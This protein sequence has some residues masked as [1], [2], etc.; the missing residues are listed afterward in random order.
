LPQRLNSWKEIAAYLGREVRTVQRWGAERELPVHRLPGGDRP[1]VYALASELDSWLNASP[2]EERA[3]ASIA[4]LPFV[5]LCGHKENE[6]FSDGLADEIINALTRVPGLRVS[7]RTSAFAFRGKEQ[8]VREIGQRLGVA[9]L[10]EG[11]VRR[12]ANRV[13]ISAQLVSAQDGYHLW[14]ECY[15]RELSDIFAIQDELAR[16]IARALRVRLVPGPLV[17]RMTEDPEAYDLWLKGRYLGLRYTQEDIAA[18]RECFE[19][20]MAR[21]PCFP[22]PYVSIA[23]LLFGAAELLQLS[24]AEARRAR[25][26]VLKALELNERLGEAHALLGTLEGVMEY[27]WDSAGRAFERAFELTP[28]SSTVLARHAWSFLVPHRR[29][30]E[31]LEEMRRATALDPLSPFLHTALGLTWVVAREYQRG[32]AECRLAIDL[33]PG[34]WW[35]HWMLCTALTFDGKAEEA[36]AE[37]LHA[38]KIGGAPGPPAALCC[39]YGLLGRAAEARQCFE[40]VLDFARTTEIPPLAMAWACIGV[41]DER[42]FEWLDK[43]ID[44]RDPSVANL[45]SMPIYDGIRGDPRFHTLLARIRINAPAQRW[46]RERKSTFRVPDHPTGMPWFEMIVRRRRRWPIRGSRATSRERYPV[47]VPRQPLV[48]RL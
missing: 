17:E 35:P 14:S 47:F 8:D 46:A 22:L 38:R 18:A 12:E 42:V 13:R 3:P 1:R 10:L 2:V 39:V 11:S 45:A 37:A 44:A 48:E 24:A 33:A 41:E 5:N 34:L 15:E 19:A 23:E 25:Q 4:V 21:D 29:I 32:E 36:I 20:A 9:T 40:Q 16:S 28:G 26:I 30:P 31:A 27:D 43:A 7:A 6:Y